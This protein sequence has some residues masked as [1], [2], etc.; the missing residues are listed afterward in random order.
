MSWRAFSW[1]E[2]S[3]F[4][5]LQ[6]IKY[7]RRCHTTKHWNVI[8]CHLSRYIYKIT[9]LLRFNKTTHQFIQHATRWIG[10]FARLQV[11][12]FGTLDPLT[13]TP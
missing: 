6:Y 4:A 9:S 2:K 12:S 8:L 1:F 7:K 10:Y 11:L 5:I 13:E 3:T